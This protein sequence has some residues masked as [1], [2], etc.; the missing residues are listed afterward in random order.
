MLTATSCVV[1]TLVLDNVTYNLEPY[2]RRSKVAARCHDCYVCSGGFHHLGC[3][4]MRCPCCGGQLISCG[5]WNDGY[6]EEEE[7][8]EEED[9]DDDYYG[10]A[11]TDASADASFPG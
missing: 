7:E 9:D 6:E 11:P 8:E 10:D 2:V 1:K 4:M 5:C 3:D